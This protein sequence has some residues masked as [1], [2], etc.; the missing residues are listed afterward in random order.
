[1]LFS[2]TTFIYLFLPTVILF[3]HV[4]L[5]KSRLLQN[6]FL[7]AASLIFYAWGEPKF[8]LVMMASIVVNWLIGPLISKIGKNGAL[9][10]C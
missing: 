10:S 7:L 5:R 1:M 8:V 6:I 9:R 4:I 2:S 3:Y